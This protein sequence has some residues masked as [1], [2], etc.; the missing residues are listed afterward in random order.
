MGVGT[1]GFLVHGL[2]SSWLANDVI[3]PAA[4]CLP[5]GSR[6]LRVSSSFLQAVYPR[7]TLFH[8]FLVVFLRAVKIRCHLHGDVLAHLPTLLAGLL[9]QQL[10][11]LRV[12]KDRRPVLGPSP[13]GIGR[14]VDPEEVVEEPFVGPLVPV[15]GHPDGLGVVL[16]V[17]VGRVLIR[18]V[19]GV[20]RSASRISNDRLDDALF[21]I[22]VALRAPE[23]SHG[24]LEGR[25]DV[26][27]GRQD[28]AYLAGLGLL[29]GEHVVVVLGFHRLVELELFAGG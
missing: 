4:A 9:R 13:A 27:G 6:F 24:R 17:A 2:T 23:S 12:H 18:G 10:L 16:D 28:W 20:P 25:V 21:A 26:L 19:V 3:F 14:G 1:Y 7:N 29:G 22:K 15:E 8:V 11:F 5:A